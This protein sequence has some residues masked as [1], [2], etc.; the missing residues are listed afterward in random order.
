MIAVFSAPKATQDPIKAMTMVPA[1]VNA[2]D[3]APTTI[4]HS[5]NSPID[6]RVTRSA[7]SQPPA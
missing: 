7:H 5:A 6:T 2:T 1:A 4:S 3:P